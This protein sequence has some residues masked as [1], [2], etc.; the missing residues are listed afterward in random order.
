MGEKSYGIIRIYDRTRYLTLLD[1]KKYDVIYNRIRYLISLK[2]SIKYIFSR[3]FAK[4]EVDSY[5]FLTI[6][7]T[8]TFHNVIIH[9]KLVLNKDKNCCC[10]KIFLENY[11]YQLAKK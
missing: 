1:T 4:I 2:I 3:N 10:C 8:L 5:D 11:L 6:E 9:I 7:I